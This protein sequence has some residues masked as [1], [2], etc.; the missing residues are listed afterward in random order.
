MKTRSTTYFQKFLSIILILTIPCIL[1]AF[2]TNTHSDINRAL[3]GIELFPSFLASDRGIENKTQD[4]QLNIVFIYQFDRDVAE[5]LSIR[6]NALGKIRGIPIQI[7]IS[8]ANNFECS[9]NK[10]I[11]G[12]FITESMIRLEEIIKKSIENQFIVFSPF[13]GDVEKGVTGGIYITERIVP[14]INL[15]TLGLAK[16]SMKSF[17]LRVS[18]KYE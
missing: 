15:K 14:Y 16:I 8:S 1:F 13:E 10:K 17:F 11:A 3:I 18:H 9:G 12:V 5:E 4:N 7:T 6:L 2:L